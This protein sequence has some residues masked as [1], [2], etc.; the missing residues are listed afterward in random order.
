MN[1]MEQPR[2]YNQI[3]LQAKTIYLSNNIYRTIAI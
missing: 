1:G 3:Q 2:S